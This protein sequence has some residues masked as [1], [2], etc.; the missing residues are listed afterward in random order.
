MVGFCSRADCC[1]CF[2][3][4]TILYTISRLQ[5]A[6]THSM[7]IGSSAREALRM[8]KINSHPTLMRSGAIV[9]NVSDVSVVSDV[10]D[11][12]LVFAALFM[13]IWFMRNETLRTLR[14]LRTLQT[15]VLVVQLEHQQ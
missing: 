4:V 6:P 2:G 12:S 13:L 14:T 7:Q 10:S 3:F 5:E 15:G 1:F 11:V 8:T 9:S